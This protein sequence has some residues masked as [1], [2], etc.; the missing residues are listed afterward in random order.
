MMDAP[1]D[2]VDRGKPPAPIEKR[3]C[4]TECGQE[5][6][7]FVSIPPTEKLPTGG[8]VAYCYHHGTKYFPRLQELV[9][10]TGGRIIDNRHVLEAEES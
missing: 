6:R 4:D 5:A 2:I 1:V 3:R 8:Q 10:N 9:I 7:V